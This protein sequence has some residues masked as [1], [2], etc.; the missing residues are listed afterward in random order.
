MKSLS[1]HFSASQSFLELPDLLMVLYQSAQILAC[2]NAEYNSVLDSSALSFNNHFGSLHQ[3]PAKYA[4]CRVLQSSSATYEL[5]HLC[6]LEMVASSCC[7][8]HLI[9]K[10][11]VQCYDHR[12]LMCQGI[13]TS[14]PATQMLCLLLERY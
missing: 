11:D 12:C 8:G 3:P 9:I 4:W 2:F 13:S 10:K 7:G 6:T 14:L 5:V 1:V